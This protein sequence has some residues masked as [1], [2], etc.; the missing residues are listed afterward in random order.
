GN[1]AGR[2]KGKPNKITRT[3]KAS[4]LEAFEELGGVQWLVQMGRGTSD[5]RRAFMGLLA[6]ILPAEINA[7]VQGGV[8]IT[9]NWLDSRKIGTSTA[10]LEHN[11]S[12]VIDLATDNDGVYK[13]MNPSQD[14]EG[15]EDHREGLD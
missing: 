12:Q 4:T 5:D 15:I 6:R 11:A 9:L 8:T 1:P 13:I 3:I 7:N 14:D 10:Q 2:G